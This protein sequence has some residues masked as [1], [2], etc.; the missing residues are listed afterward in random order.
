MSKN[1][2]IEAL[3]GNLAEGYDSAKVEETTKRNAY[4]VYKPG[5]GYLTGRKARGSRYT[6]TLQNARLFN[7][8]SDATQAISTVDRGVVGVLTLKCTL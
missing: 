2:A 7:R 6:L 8:K 3:T 1:E 5:E 4:V